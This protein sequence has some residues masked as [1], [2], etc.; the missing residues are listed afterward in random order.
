MNSAV[1]SLAATPRRRRSTGSD[2]GVSMDN[3]ERSSWPGFPS[4]EDFIERLVVQHS[5]LTDFLRSIED[6]ARLMDASLEE[7]HKIAV[8]ICRVVKLGVFGP[9]GPLDL[10]SYRDNCDNLDDA[11][12]DENDIYEVYADDLERHQKRQRKDL[13]V[14][15]S[16]SDKFAVVKRRRGYISSL[17]TLQAQVSAILDL[18]DAQQASSK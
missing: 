5:T 14:A 16:D 13:S 15:E 10:C 2:S 18:L 17:V 12:I 9:G 4:S 8:S 7:A 11:R 1:L 3:H 6:D